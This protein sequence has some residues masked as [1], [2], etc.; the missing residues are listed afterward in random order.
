VTSRKRIPEK[1]GENENNFWVG[2]EVCHTKFGAHANTGKTG[3]QAKHHALTKK[4]KKCRGDQGKKLKDKKL[5]KKERK[6]GR[7]VS[8]P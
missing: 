2:E 4:F 1:K 6:Y 7:K 8:I 3:M 5:K